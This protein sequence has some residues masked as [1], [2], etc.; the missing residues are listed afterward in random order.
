MAKSIKKPTASSKKSTPRSKKPGNNVDVIGIVGAGI[1][2]VNSVTNIIKTIGEERRRT[3]EVKLE[4]VKIKAEINDKISQRENETARILKEYEVEL[5][6]IEESIKII[7]TQSS[8]NIKRL[9]FEIEKS[10]Q[11]H[12]YRMRGLDIIEKVVDVAL[13]QYRF[14]KNDS[15]IVN[16][17]NSYVVNTELLSTMNGT[18]Q[19]LTATIAQANIGGLL[20][21]FEGE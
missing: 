21:T 14:Y 16:E 3:E 10:K 11:H 1:D 6:K 20:T 8:E 5:K 12:E 17:Y 4:G 7:E 9:D 2:A 13:E 19:Q 15:V 18:I